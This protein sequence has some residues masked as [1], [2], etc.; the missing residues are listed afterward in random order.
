MPT[1]AR[2]RCT[3]CGTPTVTSP[4][5]TCEARRQSQVDRRRPSASLRGYGSQ[6]HQRFH[7][8]VLQ[9]DPVC[10]CPGCPRCGGQARCLRP[11]TDADHHPRTRRQLVADGEDPNDPQHGRGLCHRCHSHWTAKRD[12]GFGN[13][14]T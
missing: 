4:C 1:R 5:D 8:A 14:S 6:R 2:R 11:S 9:R 7:D 13:E 12:G 10:V 3:R